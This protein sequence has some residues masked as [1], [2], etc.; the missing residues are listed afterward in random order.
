MK[1]NSMSDNELQSLCNALSTQGECE[2][3]GVKFIYMDDN[4]VYRFENNRMKKV[5]ATML[6]KANKLIASQQSYP[7]Q[8]TPTPP[9]KRKSKIIQQDEEEDNDD[10]DNDNDNDIPT[11][12]PTPTKQTKKRKSIKPTSIASTPAYDIDL[13]EYWQVKNRNEYM[14]NEIARLNNKVNK[15]KQYKQIV[16]KITG[17]EYDAYIPDQRIER[18]EPI[19]QHKPIQQY[20]DSLF[21]F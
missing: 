21:M 11:P 5:S 2:C 12:I 9:A 7:N 4:T 14:N 19:Q 15:L 20:N 18:N 6:K 17:N 8:P 3:D 16:N 13:N 10:N 1:R